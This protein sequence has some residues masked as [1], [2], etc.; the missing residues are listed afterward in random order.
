MLKK[1]I[2]ARGRPQSLHRLYPR[3]ANFGFLLDFSI[4]DLFA[5]I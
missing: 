4:N 1:R 3:T 2:Y 5:I